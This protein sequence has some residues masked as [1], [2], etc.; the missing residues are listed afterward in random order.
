VYAINKFNNKPNILIQNR[1]IRIFI[2]TCIILGFSVTTIHAESNFQTV[3]HVYVDKIHIGV[4]NNKQVVEKYIEEIIVE[5]ENETD[6]LQ[7]AINEVITYIP[8]MGFESKYNNNEVIHNLSEHLTFSIE[9][10][11]LNI[12][13]QTIGYFKDLETAK[14]V[15][16]ELKKLYAPDEI[17]EKLEEENIQD[18]QVSFLEEI[19]NKKTISEKEA[20]LLMKFNAILQEKAKKKEAADKEEVS[21]EQRITDIQL[22][23]E[24]VFNF[25]TIE[26]EQLGTVEEA[27]EQITH[28]PIGTKTHIVEENEN[29]EDILVKY[30]ITEEQFFQLN[31]EADNHGFV[32]EAGQE[33]IVPKYGPLVDVIVME[34]DTEE[35]E[36][37]YTTKYV[38]SDE[39]YKG[40]EKVLEEGKPGKIKVFY[41]IKKVNGKV[42]DKVKVKEEVIEPPVEKVIAKGTKIATTK[43]GSG[44]LNW[45]TAGGFI[46]SHMGPRWGGYHNGIDIAGVSNKTIFSAADGVVVSARFES[47]GYGNRIVIRHSNGLKTTY[48]HLSSIFVKP[49]QKVEKGQAIGIMGATGNSTGVHLHFEVYEGG[50]LVNPTKYFK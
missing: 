3:Y 22:S 40:Q 47:N 8:E 15:L 14:Q 44:V 17:V 42:V 39:L 1:L 12:K 11:E 27:L 4:V 37:E 30:Q 20:I 41:K 31:P 9:A 28:A 48:S 2:L 29:I 7:L 26:P 10:V 43:I 5:K 6:G 19:K 50:T 45:P 49:G 35:K 46:T 34:E 18:S 32:L 21:S 38:D 16:T 36:M 33:L 24:A 13:D 25:V 23:D